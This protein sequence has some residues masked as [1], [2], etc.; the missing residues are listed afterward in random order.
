VVGGG[1]GV[2]PGEHRHPGG[3]P[4]GV[5]GVPA[6][7]PAATG[8]RVAT[9]PGMVGVPTRYRLGAVGGPAVGRPTTSWAI[10]VTAVVVTVSR[11]SPAAATR[12]AATPV[13]VTASGGGGDDEAD[14]PGPSPVV[15]AA[16]HTTPAGAAVF[17]AAPRAV[18]PTAAVPDSDRELTPIRA[19]VRPS[20]ARPRHPTTFRP[21]PVGVVPSVVAPRCGWIFR[22][23]LVAA[24]ATAA[25]P[26]TARDRGPRPGPDQPDDA[27]PDFG[28]PLRGGAGCGGGGRDGSRA[29]VVFRAVPAAAAP[30]VHLPPTTA[31]FTGAVCAVNPSGADPVSSPTGT[32]TSTGVATVICVFAV[33]RAGCRNTGGD[34]QDSRRA[35]RGDRRRL[36]PGGRGEPDRGPALDRHGGGERGGLDRGPTSRRRPGSWCVQRPGRGRRSPV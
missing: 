28:C 15:V 21:V 20:A 19:P 27:G 24:A 12:R 34:D 11:A 16:Q 25:V 33:R 7:V 18:A 31:T 29:A 8:T 1:A 36:Q 30:R 14:P 22:A 4:T 17:F 10:R 9:L 32:A 23:M 3:G 2:D 6:L 5:V 26:A 13:G 35:D